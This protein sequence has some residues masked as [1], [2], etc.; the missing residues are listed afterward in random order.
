MRTLTALF[1]LIL[2]AA[3]SH[4]AAPTNPMVLIGVSDVGEY[5]VSVA[6]DGTPTHLVV[7]SGDDRTQIY[8]K[9][10]AAGLIHYDITRAGARPFTLVGEAAAPRGRPLVIGQ[11]PAGAD[12]IVVR[13]RA[14]DG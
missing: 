13:L 6:R 4:A 10:N 9:F 1:V 11:F 3:T 2:G 7:R 12:Q 5:H 8:L 14:T